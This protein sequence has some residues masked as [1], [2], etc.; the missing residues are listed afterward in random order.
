MSGA[1]NRHPLSTSTCS[2]EY[3]EQGAQVLRWQPTHVADPVLYLSSTARF[4]SGRSI[5]GGIPICWPWFG[6]GRSPGMEP[7]HGPVRPAMWHLVSHDESGDSVVTVHELS[8][9]DVS[10]PHWPHDFALRL[11][12]TFARTLTVQLSTTN[13]GSEPVDF[14]EAIHTYLVVGDIQ[15]VAIEGLSGATYVDKTRGGV[16]FVQD[17]PLTFAGETDSVY[18]SSGP[19]AVEDPVLGRRITV[20]MAGAS[21]AVVWNPWREKAAGIA[22]VGPGEWRGFVCVEGANAF[23]NAVTLE[24]GQAHTIGYELAVED[25]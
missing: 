3:V 19:I 16:Q 23:E 8:S 5:R 24:P 7:M 14:E 20:T 9:G 11:T 25:L 15:R 17:G 21:N 6:P 12:A 10:T 22:D 4:E 1:L 18:R 13:L 2:G